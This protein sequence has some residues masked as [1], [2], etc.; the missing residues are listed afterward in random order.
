[1]CPEFAHLTAIDRLVRDP[2]DG[3]EIGRELT[4]CHVSH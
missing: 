4:D 1:V 3:T 2:E